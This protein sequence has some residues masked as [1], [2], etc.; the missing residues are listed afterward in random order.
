MKKR[1][2][3]KIYLILSIFTVLI[4][5][6]SI[7]L[8]Q[9]KIIP[10]FDRWRINNFTFFLLVTLSISIIPTLFLVNKITRIYVKI[11]EIKII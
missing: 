3:V 1:F 7:I 5:T 4:P 6:S 9:Q 11:K 8:A 10:S 2:I